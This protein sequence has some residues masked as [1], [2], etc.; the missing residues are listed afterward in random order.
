[1]FQICAI[2]GALGVPLLAIRWPGWMAIGLVG[3]LWM[4]FPIQL[5]LAPQAYLFGS[6]LGGIAQGGGFAALFTV[7][8]Q[9]S[10]SDRESARLSAFVQGIGYVVAAT[11]PAVLGL[12][13]DATGAWTVPVLIVLGTTAT[14][15]VLGLAAGITQSRH[16]PVAPDLAD[17]QRTAEAAATTSTRP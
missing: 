8:V 14:F 15:T 12:A 2:V 4:S 3:V 7:V 17:P 13:H 16:H 6:V 1:M 9:V 5:L 10:H 11:G